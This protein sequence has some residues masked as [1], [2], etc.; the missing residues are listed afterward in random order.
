MRVK[1]TQTASINGREMHPGMTADL[2]P[3]F[4]AALIDTGFAVAEGA[5]AVETADMAVPET[6]VK[7]KRKR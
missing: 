1:L 5:A 7:A 2:D 4:A 6:A 3:I